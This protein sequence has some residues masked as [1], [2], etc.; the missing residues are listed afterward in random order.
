MCLGNKPELSG[1]VTLMST[2]TKGFWGPHSFSLLFI[3]KK[4]NFVLIAALKTKRDLPAVQKSGVFLIS[5]Q[6]SLSYFA[7][8]QNQWIYEG[9]LL[10][11]L[12][13]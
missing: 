6:M 2:I 4:K 5:D 12:L 8:K 10:R 7:I 11:Y 13:K 1:D 9:L 3:G